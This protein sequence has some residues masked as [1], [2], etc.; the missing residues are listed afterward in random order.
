MKSYLWIFFGILFT[1]I[2][3]GQEIVPLNSRQVMQ[4][5]SERQKLINNRVLE[6]ICHT[7]QVKQ[8]N[9]TKEYYVSEV[10]V[11]DKS[12]RPYELRSLRKGNMLNNITLFSYNQNGD[13]VLVKTF[14][15]EGNV[16]FKKVQEFS[17]SCIRKIETW[18]L[19]SNS[20]STV[21]YV[22][23]ANGCIN[24]NVFA[25]KDSIEYSIKYC[26]TKDGEL[27]QYS[28]MN[29][30][31][32]TI[33]YVEYEYNGE[34]LERKN[35]KSPEGKLVFY[36]E[37]SYDNNGN[38]QNEKKLTPG[39]NIIYHYFYDYSDSGLLQAYIKY[40]KSNNIE[41]YII[42]KYKTN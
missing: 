27:S 23:E 5:N 1:V 19:T 40:G 12:G 7:Y 21:K 20:E 8:G 15:P 35:F 4:L 13:N 6:R 30:S 38:L 10:L 17:N 9:A 32:K 18:D 24:E 22:E 29:T 33:F 26:F 37:F 25:A 41:E 39:G 31:G 3:D 28:K 14:L 36:V 2:V 16:I 11:Y 34:L 42:Y